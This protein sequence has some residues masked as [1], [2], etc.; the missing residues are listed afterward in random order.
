MCGADSHSSAPL[1][2]AL[3]A[4]RLQGPSPAVPPA[5]VRDTTAASA[6]AGTRDVHSGAQTP[7]PMT[8]GPQATAQSGDQQRRRGDDS[9]PDADPVS[10]VSFITDLAESEDNN[11]NAMLSGCTPRAQ[12][13]MTVEQIG[14]LAQT[15][16]ANLL[17][18][19]SK[20]T[21]EMAWR[22]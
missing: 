7:E 18:R 12:R 22:C 19:R 15:R 21:D 14:R 17:S 10:V 9:V 11:Y 1:A 20:L 5:S 6:D 3:R 16:V 4:T 8:V 13:D 2:P